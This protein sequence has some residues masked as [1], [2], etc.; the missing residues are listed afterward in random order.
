MG[1]KKYGHT[2]KDYTYRDEIL[3]SILCN[4]RLGEKVHVDMSEY[5]PKSLPKNM[6]P[7]PP[8]QQL[9]DSHKSRINLK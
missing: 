9:L 8:M 1:A 6:A 3:A 4:I 2:E 7:K 5:I